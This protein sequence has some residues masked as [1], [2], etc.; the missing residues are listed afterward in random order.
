MNTKV[1]YM[2]EEKGIF[3]KDISVA[4][5][6]AVVFPGHGAQYVGMFKQLYSNVDVIRKMFD[7]GEEI[8]IKLTG[9]SLLDIIF[10]ERQEAEEELLKP[11][12]MQPAIVLAD[13]AM[14][15]Y[16]LD[17]GYKPDYLIG[18]SL[19]ELAA[20]YAA[21][22]VSMEA[23]MEIAYRRAEAV[24]LIPLNERGGML[25][26]GVEYSEDLAKRLCNEGGKDCQ[27]SIINSHNQ[28]NISGSTEAINKIKKYCD[29]NNISSVVL[30]VSHAFH[31]DIM[32]PAVDPYRKSIE[33]FTFNKPEIPVYSTIL[34]NMYADEMND[35]AK[36]AGIL[37]NQLITPFNFADIIDS[38]VEDYK[39]G[40]FIEAGP[41]DIMTKL[42][43][44]I[45]GERCYVFST[46]RA[47]R[48]E[49]EEIAKFKIK[50]EC[51]GVGEKMEQTIQKD[52]IV[53]IFSRYTMYPENVFV[54]REHPVFTYYA[55]TDRIKDLIIEDISSKYNVGKNID[56]NLVSIDGINR[57]LALDVTS[58]EN[59]SG[60]V[61]EKA[62]TTMIT[63]SSEDIRE[64]VLGIIENTTGYPV[65]MLED[66]L[67]FEADLGID[68]VK[69]GEILSKIQEKYQYQVAEGE[70]IKELCNISKIVAYVS[71]KTAIGTGLAKEVSVV[72]DSNLDN[73]EEM[74]VDADEIREFILDVIE[75]KTGYPKDML[76][77]DLDFEADLGID[78][79][80]QGEIMSV[81]HDK[82]RYDV[83]EG[84][85]IKELA[86]VNKVQEY[87]CS[88]LSGNRSPKKEDEFINRQNPQL[89]SEGFSS[90][91]FVSIPVH[92][93]IG[94]ENYSF[95]GKN[96]I[97]VADETHKIADSLYEKLIKRAESVTVLSEEKSS[98]VADKDIRIVKLDESEEI[99]KV[100]ADI[101]SNN[102]TDVVINLSAI[103]SKLDI[104]SESA[105]DWE[106]ECMRV[107]DSNYYVTKAIYS[108]FENDKERTA[109][110][111]A[112]N[113]GGIYGMERGY[114]GNPVGA[115][116]AGFVKAL[117]KELRPFKCK[118]VDFSDISDSDRTA[119]TILAEASVIEKLVEV[120]YDNDGRKVVEVLPKEI[121]EDAL[122]YSVEDD[123]V[124][125]VTGGGRGIIYECVDALLKIS[126]PRVIVTG[127]TELLTH[128]AKEM[129][130]SDEEFESYRNEFF[131]EKHASDPK[132]SPV[133]IQREYDKISNKRI[134]GK[135][136]SNWKEKGYKV[137]YVQCDAANMTDMKKLI[138]NI[139]DKYGK[140]TGI[141][142][143]AGLP[144][145]GK[146]PKKDEKFAEMVV[147]VKADSTYVAM[148]ECMNEPLKFFISM[149]SISGR[150][151]MDGQVDYSAAADLLVRMTMYV[152]QLKKETRFT[153][154]GWSAWDEVGMAAGEQV[155]KVQQET[156]GL[157]YLSVKEGTSR[158]LN[159]VFFGGNYPEV[160][161][162]G[163]LGED[164][165]P[166]GQLDALDPADRRI[167]KNQLVSDEIVIDRIKYP[168]LEKIEE[169]SDKKISAVKGLTLK[170]DVHLIDHKVEGKHVFAGVMHVETACEMLEY[171]LE[172][173][174]MKD[175]RISDISGFNFY[176]FIKA[177]RGNPLEL[178][179][180]GNIVDR[181]SESIKMHVTLKSDFVNGKGMTIEKDRLHSEG[182][183]VATRSTNL[184]AE[185]RTFEND[186]Q[187]LNLDKYYDLAT[188]A[189]T[190]GET[191][192]CIYDVKLTGE[193]EIVGKVRVPNDSSYFTFTRCADTCISPVTIDNIG[194]LMLF[195]EFNLNGYTI[196]PTL[197][198]SA[199]QYRT[200]IPGEVLNVYCR[201]ESENGM[202]VVYSAY[203]LD[204]NGNLVFDIKDMRLRRIN[205]FNG[206]FNLCEASDEYSAAV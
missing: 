189:I 135:N 29:D 134:L 114:E 104:T 124:I 74:S 75:E 171:F 131:K 71:K 35:S 54:D 127:R 62:N 176:K 146:I 103:R 202:D 182:D 205:K 81:L 118:V 85:S 25:S 72:Q 23:V 61:E 37:A 150:F 6:T 111:A 109:Y 5:K 2:L 68:S 52:E 116:S 86:T 49:L 36:F 108:N 136:I 73:I 24:E 158:F 41:K 186:G 14:Y 112:T 64:F 46:N 33:K 144:S 105:E 197:I 151:G 168:M 161:I 65:D 198:D 100:V 1:R 187:L 147:K 129:Q 45:V 113:I 82:Y 43:G 191:F 166:L 20:L 163:K 101:N 196:V 60:D 50:A 42:V 40:F 7:R 152:S 142:N 175:Y 167:V 59:K 138:Q 47:K 143:G 95:D 169:I 190:F 4:E 148:K 201:F 184:S 66:E 27:V 154:M 141:V 90:G 21:K 183:I 77:E 192:K 130:M 123:D 83:E 133:A 193:R 89:I 98:V 172:A 30:K 22:V 94:K 195:R 128:D 99:K 160:L 39:V 180:E 31:S 194:R 28:F 78:S 87:I 106:K 97:I 122:S 67:D 153:V 137:E 69:Q 126:S 38:L 76:G 119:E 84:E 8:Y 200:M 145:F 173:N 157:E 115:I 58:N 17:M 9:K 19:G 16:I 63:E 117:E 79:V 107:Y 55:I 179:I 3:L 140:I 26:I 57:E 80:K 51:M 174:D 159:E 96:I 32:T 12:A 185:K 110:F 92:K 188:G 48:D 91:R 178:K 13:I 199:V 93:E 164:N 165:L 177:F 70:S 132:L 206:D 181:N 139:K 34:M 18:H 156:R 121:R 56:W 11:T 162:F 170:N 149:G 120:G 53:G 155:K 44:N 15:E 204:E 125:L 102:R 10:S 203:A 88:K